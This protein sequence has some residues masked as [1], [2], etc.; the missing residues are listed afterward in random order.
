MAAWDSTTSE[1]P[2]PGKITTGPGG[3]YVSGSNTGDVTLAG[4]P[5][6]LT[7]VGQVIT[8]ALINLASHVTGR[9]PF[10]NL[11]QIAGRSV[12]GVA[13]ASTADVAP[14]TASVDGQVLTRV[15]GSLA[16]AMPASPGT[17]DVV[18]PSASVDGEGALFD[19]TTGKLLKRATGTG[20]VRRTSGVDSVAE[21]SGDVTTSGSNAATVVNLPSGVT[22]AGH[23]LATAVAAPSTPAAGNGKVYVD[24]TSKN[25]AVK[26]DA[27]VVKHGVR[28]LASSSGQFVTAIDD[29]GTVHTAAPVGTGAPT[30]L[31]YP[32][33]N[34]RLSTESGVV[35]SLTD[36]TAKSTIYFTPYLGAQVGLYTS[37]AWV[38]STFAELSLALSSLTSDK[39]YDVFLYDNAG[40]LTLELSAAWTNDTTR[41]DALALQ[42]GVQVKSSDHSRR[43]LGTFRTTGTT[44]TEDSFAKRYIWNMYN[45][46][47]RPLACVRET[48]DSWNYTTATFR[49]ANANTANQLN[50]VVGLAEDLVHADVRAIMGNSTNGTPA[51]VG[52][53]IDSTSV[54]G[55]LSYGQNAPVGPLVV[56]QE[57]QYRGIP[58][59]GYHF[60]AWLEYSAATGTAT[61]YGDAGN[62][63]IYQSRMWGVV[64]A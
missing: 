11:T 42:D 32:V 48:T 64:R 21:L 16:F 8:R 60:L 25:L 45:R 47:E 22:Q 35:A 20:I 18:G 54:N 26:D 44:T 63:T 13:G 55:G 4:T 5:N 31:N 53:G 17:G 33:C 40:T 7:I 41:A 19:G 24:S 14:I 50:Y 62:A 29:D 34:G 10:A 43:Y 56:T 38:V 61:W 27:G 51:A 57:A 52:I 12:L 28:T 59:L 15:A 23:L 1:R 6:Y 58:G 9:L 3:G 46:L 36:Q 30:G 39:N 49:Q 37:G 2:R